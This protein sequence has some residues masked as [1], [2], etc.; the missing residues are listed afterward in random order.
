MT[1]PGLTPR[2]MEV[3][4]CVIQGKPNKIIARELDV[5]VSAIRRGDAGSVT[6][7]GTAALT[8]HFMPPILADFHSRHP[9]AEI[10]MSIIQHGTSVEDLLETGREF[11][12]M[13]R[14]SAAVGRKFVIEPF[15]REPVIVV[16]GPGHPLAHQSVV[17]PK[18]VAQ[19][20]FIY[21]SRDSERISLLEQR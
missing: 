9:S 10:Q 7:A 17:T 5:S 19:Q 15:R 14:R 3:L 21:F 18:E 20:P 12:V 16:A 8:N 6:F 13:P 4:R 1:L 11:A 2:Q